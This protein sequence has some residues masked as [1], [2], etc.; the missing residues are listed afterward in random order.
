MFLLSLHLWEILFPIHGSLSLCHLLG[1]VLG[2][3]LVSKALLCSHSVMEVII[4]S[5]ISWLRSICTN[6][7]QYILKSLGKMSD[8]LNLF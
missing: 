5:C 2:K 8:C 7:K 4:F 6:Y 3:L 1:D